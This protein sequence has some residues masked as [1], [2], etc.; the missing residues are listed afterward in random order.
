MWAPRYWSKV[1]ATPTP[2]TGQSPA[3]T[4]YRMG[5]RVQDIT[6]G[7]LLLSLALGVG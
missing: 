4:R 5:Y 2:P 3:A 7:L 1:G 6:V